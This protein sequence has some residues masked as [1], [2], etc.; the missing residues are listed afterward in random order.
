[1]QLRDTLVYNLRIG[2]AAQHLDK[3]VVKYPLNW[4]EAA[5]QVLYHWCSYAGGG[6]WP[7]FGE[8]FG[9]K[10][11]PVQENVITIDVK[12]LYPKIAIPDQQHTVQVFRQEE[13]YP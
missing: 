7:W 12:A 13:V 3:A 4:R 9:P 5:K 8:D 1:M 2:I 6:H 10:R 11:W